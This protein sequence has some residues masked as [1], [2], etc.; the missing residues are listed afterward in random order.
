M[1]LGREDIQRQRQYYAR[2]AAIYES[3]HVHDQ[4]EHPLAL[5]LLSAMIPYLGARSVLDVGSGT[6]RAIHHLKKDHPEIRSIGIEP[7]HDL[8]AVGRQSGLSD[9]DLIPGDATALCFDDGQ[10]DV[11]CSFGVLHHI[12][13]PSRAVS[14]MLRVGK[15]AVF[16]SDC[17]IYGQG[18]FARRTLK[19]F[20]RAIHLWKAYNFV[21]TRGKGYM[22]NEGDGVFY[23]YSI[24][25]NYWQIRRECQRVH[26][27]NT[28][29]AWGN[30]YRS[31]DHIALLGVKKTATT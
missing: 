28:S 15:V 10:F 20:L 31:A 11:V 14:E 23:P 3:L 18:A 22:F 9:R 1:D 8:I 19:Q 27:L 2:T 5:C 29:D 17:N 12:R 24:F 16:I 30:P 4:G 6:G 26:I 7:S 13:Q 25:D 21:R